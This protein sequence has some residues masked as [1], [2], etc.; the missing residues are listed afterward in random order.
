[1]ALDRVSEL[2]LDELGGH[3]VALRNGTLLRLSRRHR[4]GLEA[5]LQSSP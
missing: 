3:R 2:R 4:E 5:R 1:V